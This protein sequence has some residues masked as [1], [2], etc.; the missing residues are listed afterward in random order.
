MALRRRASPKPTAV[1][2]APPLRVRMPASADRPIRAGFLLLP[3][4][5]LLP[6]SSTVEPLR[7]ANQLSGATIFTWKHVS[8]DG[9]PVHASNGIA[10]VADHGLDDQPGLDI[11]FVCAGTGIEGFEHGPTLSWLRALARQGVLIAGISGGPH[12]L[13]S[14]GVLDGYRAT[15]HWD[16]MPGFAER[17]PK[18]AL[19]G[20]LYEIDRDRITCSGGVAPLDLMHT[21]IAAWRGQE[22]ATAVSEW[23]VQSEVRE[24][25][26]SQR[27]ALQQRFRVSH[28]RLLDVLAQMERQIEEPLEREALAARAGLSVRQLER[29]FRSYLGR[30]IGQHYLELRLLRARTL[31]QQTTLS[32]LEV[33]VATGFVSAT[34]FSRCYSRRFGHAPRRERRM[35]GPG[36]RSHVAIRQVHVA[37]G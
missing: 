14:A 1:P 8:L 36:D 13:A 28:P 19:T 34:H 30:T 27:M 25:D 35:E 2:I 9:R 21:L 29:L 18:V 26:R 33:A 7:A 15:I 10:L 12:V 17:F 24:P 16:H 11:V 32:V 4:F 22:L 6:Y 37:K 20:R 23:F 3:G 31:M 5:A